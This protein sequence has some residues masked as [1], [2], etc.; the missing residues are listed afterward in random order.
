MEHWIEINLDASPKRQD[1]VLLGFLRP[2]VETLRRKRVLVTWHYFREPE[3]RFR[4]RLRERRSKLTEAKALASM[5]NSL[6]KRGLIGEWHF[7][8]HG[9]KGRTY[10]GEEDR[11]G[12]EGWKVA[13]RYFNSGAE[14]ALSL[15]ELK[16]RG[17]LESPLW[18][19]GPGNP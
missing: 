13:Q 16:R 11:Y 18:A 17:S 15:L 10:V 2:W 9:E 19:K 14:A 4:V 3:I 6:Q 7:G 5:A 12:R 8:N 1:E